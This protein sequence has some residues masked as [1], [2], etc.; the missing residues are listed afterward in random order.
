ME[1]HADV[2]EDEVDQLDCVKVILK[3]KTLICSTIGIVA[4]GTQGHNAD[5]R[6]RRSDA[7]FDSDTSSNT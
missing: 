1:T 5:I 7:R 4:V 6:Q 2:Y 3:N